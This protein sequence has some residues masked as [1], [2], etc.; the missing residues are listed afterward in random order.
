MIIILILTL[1]R[2]WFL[3]KLGPEG[4]LKV[5]C[6]TLSL[7]WLVFKVWMIISSTV[8]LACNLK[9]SFFMTQI[10]GI[11]NLQWVNLDSQK[12]QWKSVAHFLPRAAENCNPA[13]LD[14]CLRIRL[15]HWVGL[16]R[17]SQ[18]ISRVLMS[19]NFLHKDRQNS[20]RIL[21]ITMWLCK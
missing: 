11:L 13:L 9:Q 19:E 14:S 4:R 20:L 3:K 21:V 17:L 5:H 12:F 10:W 6:L 8:W 2:K 1:P 18:W 16:N 7:L 15:K